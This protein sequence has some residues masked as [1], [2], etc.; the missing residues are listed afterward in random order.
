MSIGTGIFLVAT[1]AILAFAVDIDSGWLRVNIVGYVLI[2]T[3]L[4]ML[5]MTLAVWSK[6]RK[7]G[8]VVQKKVVENGKET[9]SERRVYHGE[10]PPE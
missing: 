8:T 10:E 2:L 5:V 6:R 1:G 9:S 3:G 7:E 4:T